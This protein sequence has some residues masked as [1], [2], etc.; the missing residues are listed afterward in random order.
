MTDEPKDTTQQQHP[1]AIPPGYP[2][3]W[4][5]YPPEDEID[6]REY[7]KLI[8]DN[9]K[10]VSA[11]TGA[12]TVLA[13][14]ISILM[15]PIYRAEVL[16]SP[17]TDE[18]TSGLSALAGQFGD[19]ASLVGINLSGGSSIDESIATLN[20]RELTATFVKNED[21]LPLLFP[22]RW[23]GQK[24]TWVKH[25]WDFSDKDPK[26]TEW[27]AYKIF[28][29]KIR[30][31]STDTKSNLV[32]VSIDWKDPML[33]AKWANDLVRAVN[34]ARR[35]EAINEA[36]KSIRFL[37]DQLAKT[38]SVEV[39]QSIYKLIEAQTKTKML[40]STREEYAFKVIDPAVPP[41]KKIRPRRLLITVLGAI[42]GFLV[43]VIVAF[44]RRRR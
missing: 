15:T 28:N 38:G 42:G 11:V 31:V 20:S 43:G 29:D 9:K 1:P 25:W 2:P 24:G 4:A 5:Y 19:I 23:D 12:C 32:T 21:M 36:N 34:T 44:V 37:E 8:V 18:K 26:P 14:V 10:L 16:L 30:D 22:S 7:W 27:D 3:P 17:V 39:Q 41:E 6:L 13:L 33:A 40:A 35:E